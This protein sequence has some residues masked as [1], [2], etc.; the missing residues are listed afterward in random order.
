MHRLQIALTICLSSL[1]CLQSYWLQ[2]QSDFEWLETEWTDSFVQWNLYAN[3]DSTN[4]VGAI[5]MVWLQ[6]NDWSQWDIELGDYS[7]NV[8][9][10]IKGDFSD[11]T[12]RLG[13]EV[14]RIQQ[15]WP[16]SWE[17]WRLSFQDQV[18]MLKTDDV[19]T[20]D[21]FILSLDR[22]TTMVIFTEFEGDYRTWILEQEE[23][24]SPGVKLA[25]SFI[26]LFSSVPH[27]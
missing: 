20:N 3:L 2:S 1:F 22:K 24:L 7:G 21:Y 13:N 9:S 26:A 4:E 15:R 27:Y 16:N 5:D 8:R 23:E 12:L 18:Y 10:N 14:V 11:W 17:E 6:Q 19:V 25:A